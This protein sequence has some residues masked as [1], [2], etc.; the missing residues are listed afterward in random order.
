MHLGQTPSSYP[1]EGRYV[2]EG[3]AMAGVAP[4]TELRVQD[5]R[6]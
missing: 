3:A 1:A 2:G 4:S 6:Y 5:G